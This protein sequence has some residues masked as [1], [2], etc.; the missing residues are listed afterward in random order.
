VILITVGTQLPFDRLVRMMDELAPGLD[1]P[2]FAQI[3]H[4]AYVPRNMEW[5]RFVAPLEFEQRVAASRFIVSHAGVGTVVTAERHARGLILFPRSA[6]LGEHR[7]D[8]QLATAAA[9]SGR[10]GIAVA[11]DLEELRALIASPPAGPPP[12]TQA[13]PP[14]QI[15]GAVADFLAKLT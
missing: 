1:E 15:C 9:L 7:N 12:S 2:V 6:K 8:H 14:S 13:R 3:G 11:H 5:Q 10:A 4:G